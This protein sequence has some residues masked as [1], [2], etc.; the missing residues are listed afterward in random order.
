MEVTTKRPVPVADSNQIQK[1]LDHGTRQLI[2][3]FSAGVVMAVDIPSY[4]G[5]IEQLHIIASGQ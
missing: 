4:P 5:S 3:Y 1:T 2:G